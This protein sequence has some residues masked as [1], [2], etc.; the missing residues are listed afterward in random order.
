[1]SIVI[2]KI[3]FKDSIHDWSKDD[4]FKIETDSKGKRYVRIYAENWE[5]NMMEVFLSE[6]DIKQITDKLEEK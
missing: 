1:M 4:G 2:G 6:K 3:H 5:G